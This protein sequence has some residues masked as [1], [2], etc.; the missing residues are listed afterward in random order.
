VEGASYLA[1][2]RG[3]EPGAIT[4]AALAAVGGIERFVR[5]G[6]DVIIKP[7]ICVDYRTYEYGATTNPQVVAALVGLCGGAGA[8]R[9]RVMDLPFGGSPESAYAV[10]GIAEVVKTAG[11]AVEVMN[12]AKFRETEIP[13]G[14]DITSWKVYADLLSADVVINVPVAKHHSLAR[15]SLGL[16]NLLGVVLNPGRLHANLG[17]RVADLASLVRPSLTVVDAV[18]T[19]MTHGPTG[20]NLNDVRLTNTVIASHDMVAADAYAAT[21][22]DLR[23]KDIAYVA[24]AADMG[25]GTMDLDAIEVAEFS[26]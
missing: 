14:R 22:F 4:Q 8:K 15:L 2:V 3:Q 18:R 25:L 10:S 12:P 16:K 19:L 21:L 6:D 5:P 24:A 26:V 1:A 23:G 20:G 9:V 11:G 7:N 17:Q 13:E